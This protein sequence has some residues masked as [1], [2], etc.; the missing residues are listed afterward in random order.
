M[1][2]FPLVVQGE[3]EPLIHI[4]DLGMDLHVFPWFCMHL[5][6]FPWF[7]AW[8]CMHF[9]GFGMGSHAFSWF[10]HCFTFIFMVC[11]VLH[12]FPL[13]FGMV[14]HAFPWFWHGFASISM[15][16]AWVCMHLHGSGMV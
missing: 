5:H 4:H 7:F 10:R 8:V 14:L 1:V 9:Y 12:A 15:V 16:S 6:A 3:T 13:F 2:V 11:I